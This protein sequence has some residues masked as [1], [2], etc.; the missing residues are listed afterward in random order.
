MLKV[1]SYTSLKTYRQ[2]AR[3]YYA[4]YIARAVK[5]TTNAAMDRG[6]RVHKAL[7]DAV[8]S[9]RAPDDIWTP[10]GLTD[11]LRDAG[12]R[13]EVGIGIARD[14]TA[15]SPH[16]PNCVLRGWIDALMLD[17]AGAVAIDWK[18][19]KFSPD[20]LQADVYATLLR[21]GRAQDYPVQ[22]SW[23]YVDQQ[24]VHSIDV[25]ANATRRVY[26]LMDQL[27]RDKSFSPAPSYACRWCP[28]SSCTYYE[29]K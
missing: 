10:D 19:G 8:R 20:Y 3:Q 21:A 4:M 6:N 7:E 18:T 16:D 15:A 26:A 11:V 22:F 17:D 13:S 5:R 23:I 1:H 29:G 9:G 25:D 27:E 12:A 14:G 24:R 2:C 28:V